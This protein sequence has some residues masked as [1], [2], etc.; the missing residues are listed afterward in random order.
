M[1]SL[2]LKSH[3]VILN[4]K[5]GDMFLSGGRNVMCIKRT[6]NRIYLSTG[7][8]ITI[9]R[10]DNFYYLQGKK[11]EQILRDIEGFLVYKIHS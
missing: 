3:H 7:D 9:K 6:P 1:E 10:C 4:M 11:V 5:V 8:L 2:W